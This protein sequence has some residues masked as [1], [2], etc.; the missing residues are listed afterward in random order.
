MIHQFLPHG[1]SIKSVSQF[2]QHV[3]LGRQRLAKFRD[4]GDDGEPEEYDLSRVTAPVV[5]FWGD[6]DPLASEEDVAWLASQLGN[7]VASIRVE[8]PRFNHFDFLIGRNVYHVLYRRILA[9]LPS[10]LSIPSL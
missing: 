3:H 4:D 8:D 1:V 7:C 9:L 10:P 2:A 5:I 6:N